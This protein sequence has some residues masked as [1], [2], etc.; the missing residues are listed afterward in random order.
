M[1][2]FTAPRFCFGPAAVE[3]VTAIGA[4]RV[5]V[6]VDRALVRVPRFLRVREELA[7]ADVRSETVAEITAE[8]TVGS[9]EEIAERLRA[10]GPDVVLAVGGGSTID[11]GKGAWARYE[12][13]DLPL[14]SITPLTELHLRRRARFMAVPTTVG[15]GSE[16]N[17]LAQFHR[18]GGAML[19]IGSREFEPDWA[20][21]D[22]NF[23]KSL[24]PAVLAE[25]AFDALAHAF[26]ATASEWANPF[27]DALARDAIGTIFRELPRA[28]KHPEELEALG[29]LQVAAGMAGLAASNAQVGAVHAIAHAIGALRPIPHA[30]V[31]SVL[32][33]YVVE[34]NFLSARERYLGLQGVLGPGPLQSRGALGSR[35]RQFAEQSGVPTNLVRAGIPASELAEL[36]GR[37]VELAAASPSL[38]GNPRMPSREELAAL[39]DAATAGAPLP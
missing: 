36:R 10:F 1:G 34:F 28:L 39:V 38:V 15:S 19:E 14:D 20:I 25:T 6:L 13:P 27:A 37:I 30:R 16:A 29:A 21:L 22:P 11:T 33:P 12:S 7:K 4:T 35:L 8:P 3:Q 24:P 17:G 18:P 32:L 5:A 9:V 31:A 26:E 23:V 2:F